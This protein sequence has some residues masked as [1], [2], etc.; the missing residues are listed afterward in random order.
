MLDKLYEKAKQDV[1]ANRCVVAEWGNQFTGDD[2]EAF[3]SSIS[4][5]DFSNKSLFNLYKDAGAT[6]SITSLRTHRVGE[7]GCR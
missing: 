5:D 7:C 4:D 2:K 1:A 3:I 6:F